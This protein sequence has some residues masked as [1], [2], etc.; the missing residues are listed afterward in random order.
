[1]YYKKSKSFLRSIRNNNN[2]KTYYVLIVLM[3]AAIGIIAAS[4]ILRGRDNRNDDC[5]MDRTTIAEETTETTGESGENYVSSGH[6]VIY[7]L[8]DDGITAVCRM[9]DVG[10]IIEVVN[11]AKCAIGDNVRDYAQKRSETVLSQLS[12]V[13]TKAIWKEI[14]PDT[15]DDAETNSYFVQYYSMINGI[16]FHS[17]LYSENG[18]YNSIVKE[19]YNTISGYENGNDTA[20][21]DGRLTEPVSGITMSAA[22]AHW[23]YENVPGTT[24]IYVC[25]SLQNSSLS[26][27]VF[28][29]G[30]GVTSDSINNALY[31]SV[32]GQYMQNGEMPGIPRGFHCDPTDEQA[33]YIFSPYKLGAINNVSDKIVETG[34]IAYSFISEESPLVRIIFND[35]T[36]T[37][38]EGV[39]IS[40]YLIAE[41]DVS[42]YVDAQIAGMNVNGF[43]LPGD[44]V[45]RFSA[46]DKYGTV[47]EQSCYLH[48][49]DTTAPVISL[50]REITEINR[51]Q[52]ENPEY[53][54]DMVTVTELCK[55]TD[56]G[57]TYTLTED[58]DN[59][60][61]TFSASDVY[62]NIG[63]LDIDL[64]R[65][66]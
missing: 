53:I 40:E 49:V 3:L 36:L 34:Q 27:M 41:A 61:I 35:V 10:N 14:S 5:I 45:V 28:A 18:N 42:M 65:V 16:E 11:A 2:N 54:R 52:I 30:S 12:V 48:V 66:D 57:M 1:M 64:K 13:P 9:D 39:D 29:D 22:S 58:G 8:V 4:I 6:Y 37:S 19:S 33:N 62:G 55:L 63:T 20:G 47:L 25:E 43:L 38:E 51:A 21:S 7:I 59:V 32:D 60:H 56:D 26:S 31:S 44:Y 17:A 24:D 15:S 50:N 23:F 46:A